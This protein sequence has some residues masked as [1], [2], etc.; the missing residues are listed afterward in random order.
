MKPDYL[1]H[2]SQGL[3]EI[4]KPRQANDGTALGSQCAIYACTNFHEVIPFALPIRWYPD[5]P[6]G[7]KSFSCD[8]NG[9]FIE[10]GSI[11]PNGVGYVYKISAEHFEQIDSRQWISSK[12]IIPAEVTEIRVMDYWHTITF[13]DEAPKINMELYPDPELYKR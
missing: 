4:L 2:G 11:N 13:S 8:S 3:Y 10:Y 1:Y 12:E 7:R 6:T 9:T 5:N